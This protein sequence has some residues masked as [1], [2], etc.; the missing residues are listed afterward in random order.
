MDTASLI[1][2][3]GL[4]A[5]TLLVCLVSGFVPVVNAELFLIAVSAYAE[6]TMLAPVLLSATLGQ[7]LA[8]STMYLG[9]LGVVELPKGKFAERVRRLRTRME[10]WQGA[11]IGLV[12]V[13]ASTGLPPF[14][15]VSVM[16]GGLGVG[17]ARFF[18]LG[19]AGRLL[20]FGI[21]LAFPQLLK[22][23]A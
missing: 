16:A 13:S 18:A 22:S 17:F 4:V 23:L 15:V 21:F 20:R 8:K 14:Y 3:F 5:G 9:G 6:P 10:S 12:F 19:F 7:M 11:P 2:S 1:E